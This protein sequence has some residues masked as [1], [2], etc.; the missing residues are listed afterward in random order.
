[1]G[2]HAV[3]FLDY[4]YI[5]V[6]AGD[7]GSGVVSFAQ[8]KGG[9]NLGPDGG[10]GGA[11]GDVWLV[12]SASLNTLNK[13]NVGRLY[14][15]AHGGHGGSQ[16]KTGARGQDLLIQVPC[17]TEVHL[18]DDWSFQ[19]SS[20]SLARDLA[21]ASL[22]QL[23]WLDAPDQ[24]LLVAKGGKRGLGNTAFV[25]ATEQRPMSALPGTKG[26]TRY[27]VLKLKLL[28]HVGLA[29]YPN[30]GK[31]SLLRALSRAKPKV[32]DY[33]FTTV[34]PHLGVIEPDVI[35]GQDQ[36]VVV[37]DI[38]GLL[39]GAAQGR[40]LGNEFLC[41]L[42]KT[43]LLVL[44]ICAA[45]KVELLHQQSRLEAT[46]AE[47]S[48]ELQQKPKLVFVS[49]SDRLTAAVKVELQTAL[50]ESNTHAFVIG[51]AH[52]GEGIQQLKARLRSDISAR[53][54]ESSAA[55]DRDVITTTAVTAANANSA[56][57]AYVQDLLSAEVKV[58]IN[59]SPPS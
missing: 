38:P 42:E 19:Q 14:K 49:Q 16:K 22:R 20:P 54:V 13:I 33:P 4:A 55:R 52:T 39:E 48:E 7:G 37:A 8:R 57:H 41:H 25:S 5:E 47:F 1:M 3:S 34:C 10:H 17:G 44:V 59:S 40:G 35:K 28:A 51:S 11:G 58:M 27:L 29:G 24:R 45:S 46:L 50:I 12:A 21:A 53:L 26:Q 9:G 23:G 2:R 6:A 18:V 31:S 56:A 43:A 36:P 32:A 30:A 15:A